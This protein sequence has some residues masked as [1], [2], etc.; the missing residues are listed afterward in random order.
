MDLTKTKDISDLDIAE[1]KNQ[2]HQKHRAKAIFQLL[3][4]PKLCHN[5]IEIL[6]L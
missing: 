3:F 1:T 2:C 6:D 5:I 4:I